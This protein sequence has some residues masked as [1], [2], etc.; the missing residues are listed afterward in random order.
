MDQAAIFQKKE[1]RNKIK[2]NEAIQKPV[3]L[4]LM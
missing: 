1:V 2:A 4:F 3:K